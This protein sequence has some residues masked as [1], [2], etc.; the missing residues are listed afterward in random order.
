VSYSPCERNND[1][2][3]HE[4][5][6]AVATRC[7]GRPTF[8]WQ[9][10]RFVPNAEPVQSD[11][12]C[13]EYVAARPYGALGTRGQRAVDWGDPPPPTDGLGLFFAL[14]HRHTWIS[15]SPMSFGHG[16]PDDTRNAMAAPIIASPPP[17]EV[18]HPTSTF[19]S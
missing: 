2:Y 10:G 12:V 13:D 5:P 17:K 7:G 8:R 14:A 9:V 1:A 16:G 4:R 11:T 15:G 6:A 19:E 18:G 3:P